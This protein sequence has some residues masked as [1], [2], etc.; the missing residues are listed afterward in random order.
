MLSDTPG[1]DVAYMGTATH[2]VVLSGPIHFCSGWIVEHQP[3][4]FGGE[5]QGTG[6]TKLT[7]RVHNYHNFV[8]QLWS[9]HIL[10]DRA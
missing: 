5:Q 9:R 2:H 8:F 6:L 4:A 10:Q 7:A 3:R 1:G